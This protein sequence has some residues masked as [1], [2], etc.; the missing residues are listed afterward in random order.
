MNSNCYVL[1]TVLDTLLKANHSD[2]TVTTCLTVGLVQKGQ[3][4]GYTMYMFGSV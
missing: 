2:K 3:Y 4:P 1:K